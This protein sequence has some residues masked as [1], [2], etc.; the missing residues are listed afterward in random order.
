MPAPRPEVELRG[1]PAAPGIAV[2]PV[3]RYRHGDARG[4]PLPDVRAAADRASNELLALAERVRG[5]GRSDEAEIFDAQALMAVDPMLLEEAQAR[6]REIG[7]ADPDALAAAVE[8]VARAAAETL[9]A[10]PDETLAARGADVR[11]VGSRIARI[12]AGRVIALPDRPSIAIADDLPPSITAD[13][14]PGSL[15]GIALEGGSPVSHATILARGLGIPAVVAVRGLVAATYAAE[16][17]REAAGET[18]GAA[19]LTAGLDGEAGTLVLGPSAEQLA[20]FDARREQRG[21]QGTAARE[22]RG[23]PGRTADGLAVPL[24]ANI[25]RPEDA[26]RALDAGAEGVGLFRTEFLFIGRSDPPSEDEQ[27]T[28]YAAVLR[29][30]GPERQVVIRLADIGGDK[31]I[32]YLHLAAE[33]NPFLGVR[34][35]RLGY[36]DRA[37]IRTQVRAIARAGAAA[38]ATP[39]L[40]AP[41][42]STFEDVTMLREIVADALASLDAEGVARAVRLVVGIMVEVPSAALCAPELAT[43]VDFFSIGSNDLTQYVLAMDRTNARLAAA[44]DALHP[45]V[46]R[47]IRATVDGADSRGIPV[48]ICGE[49]A[50]DPLGAAVLVGLGVDELSMDAGALDDVRLMLS[51]VTSAD[52]RELARVA[53]RARTATEVRA[54][55]A[56]VVAAAPAAAGA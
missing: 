5:L 25:G 45:A 51:R 19:I 33:G 21:R 18:G 9:A 56:K 23:R 34:G 24:L 22:L 50:A 28:A 4:V 43:E 42:V 35:L 11:D 10:L 17:G 29:A 53:L 54:A 27:V 48:A 32:P 30:F 13:L 20:A 40:M 31:A 15:L 14:P 7:T 1:L 38:A 37:L 2:G 55:A 8:A 3:W 49:L 41:M 39:S 44:A 12:V 36:D 46:L 6:A 16:A 52:L 26:A 47:A